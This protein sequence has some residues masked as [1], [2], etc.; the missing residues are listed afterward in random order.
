LEEVSAP[1]A[2]F[3]S[4]A[5]IRI[6]AR[7]FVPAGGGIRLHVAL[8]RRNGVAVLILPLVIAGLPGLRIA[9]M[10]GDPI[11]QYCEI[12]ADP[13][14]DASAAFDAAIA[15]VKQAGAD[16]I[17][18]RRIREDSHLLKLARPLLRP[19]ISR[20]A[21]PFADLSRFADYRAYLKSLSH[22]TRHGL[23]NRE[24][25]LKNAGESR[26]EHTMGGRAARMALADA[27]DLKRKWLVQRGAMSS[28]LLDT[29]T[30]ACLLDLTDDPATGSVVA[31]LTVNDATAAIRFGFEYRNTHFTYLSAYDE[32]FAGLSPGKLLMH[33]VLS[34]FKERGLQ[35]VDMLPP[36]GRHKA[37]W[38]RSE[39]GVADYTLPL[40]EAGRLYAIVYQ[41]RVRPGLQRV[42]KRMPLSLR[43]LIAAL[44][45]RL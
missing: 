32:R 33:F 37:E 44:L 34:S 11:A 16:A 25:R 6:W 42:W 12:L 8:V 28:A 3:Q 10:A 24:H 31:R 4:H 15:S 14:I 26:F 38:C 23:K 5:Q 36:A 7:H 35:R 18:F 19:P 45:L 40:S 29:E 41:E 43:S 20:Q 2:I 1:S 9:R 17:V 13:T 21:A 39:V 30:K 22:K 27:M